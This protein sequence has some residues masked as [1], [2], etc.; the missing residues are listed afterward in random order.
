MPDIEETEHISTPPRLALIF[1]CYNEEAM[2][3][4]CLGAV[5][6]FFDTLKNRRRIA[7]DSFILFVDDGSSD[8]TWRIIEDACR[9]DANIKAVKLAA[10]AGHQNALL[11]GMA[12]VKNI[13]DCAVTMD[14]D[15]QDDMAA[16]I[17]MLEMFAEGNEI[18]Y[19]VR[20]KREV[21]SLFKKKT[22]EWFYSLMKIMK[23]NIVPNHA[24]FRLVS[25]KALNALEQFGEYNV[26]LR[27]IFPSLGFRTTTVK[28]ERKERAA[29]ETKYPLKKM[30][31]FALKGITMF[32]P[33]PLRIA[34]VFS[35][36]VL[37][38]A[39]IQSCMVLSA[40]SKGIAVPGWSST[41]IVIL[42][43]GAVQLLCIAIIGEY[44]AKIFMEVKKRPR[45]IVEKSI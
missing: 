21:D 33:A 25:K 13:A 11:A 9:S 29:G 36:I 3:P 42:V 39:F 8:G 34:G 27:G 2:L 30:I 26:F 18:V 41:M 22:A 43:L 16:I 14:A 40:Y 24:D 10:N 28:Y 20:E 19:G 37:V 32:S 45:Y 17:P 1:P 44:I 15:L 7:E 5:K 23:V 31:S 38:F 6:P 12:H 4:G 35:F